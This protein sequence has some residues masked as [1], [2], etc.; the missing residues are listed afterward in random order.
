[1]GLF[2]KR[3]PDRQWVETVSPLLRTLLPQ[4]GKYDQAVFDDSWEDQ[5]AA[6]ERMGTDIPTTL[7]L[8][9][10]TPSPSS[11]KTRQHKR[12]LEWALQRY[13]KAMLEGERV[14]NTL[15]SGLGARTQWGGMTGGMAAKRVNLLGL[16]DN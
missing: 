14:I 10:S 12:N 8:I 2:G 13:V 1:M 4:L 15:E 16:I 6:I 9:K 3:I 5:I 7:R 11:S